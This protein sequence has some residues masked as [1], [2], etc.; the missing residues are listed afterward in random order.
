MGKNFYRVLGVVLV[1]VLFFSV[2]GCTSKPEMVTDQNI[3]ALYNE[4][5][6]LFLKTA[7][8]VEEFEKKLENDFKNVFFVYKDDRIIA[9]I[10]DEQVD[11]ELPD[12]VKL[13]VLK[14]FQKMDSIINEEY[15]KEEYVLTIN[16]RVISYLSKE[17]EVVEFVFS[18]RITRS[19]FALTYSEDKASDSI[20]TIN[21]DWY[22]SWGGGV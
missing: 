16:Y 9:Y 17:N 10:I 3:I 18:N 14:C 11:I 4:N 5:Q 2:L 15:E 21:E 20:K 22:I 7:K 13:D 6:E 1:L 8:E 12:T 19:N